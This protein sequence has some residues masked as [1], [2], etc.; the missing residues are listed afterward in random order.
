MI[1][2]KWSKLVVILHLS[3]ERLTGL[4]PTNEAWL[5]LDA[6]LRD[7]FNVK[8]GFSLKRIEEL[9]SKSQMKKYYRRS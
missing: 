8:T 1:T 5:D 2:M 7:D 3:M 9:Q 6:R 4:N